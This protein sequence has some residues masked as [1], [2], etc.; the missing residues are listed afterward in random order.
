MS[1]LSRVFKN[2]LMLAAVAILMRT[3]GVGFNAYLKD[4][5]GE[6]GMGLVSLTLSVYGFAVTF[7]TSGL[8]LS[9]TRLVAEA[10]GLGRGRSIS[11]TLKA[12]LGYALFFGLLAGG[13]LFFASDG[14]ARVLLGD[15]RTRA[16]LR[17]LAFSLPPI[18]LSGV[19]Q[20]YFVAVGREMPRRVETCSTLVYGE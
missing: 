15:V 4:A 16:S 10:L 12:A 6:G 19:F 17:L 7:A 9:V 5:L 18:A 8:S 14:I 1:N 20:G 2:G 3:G 13:V 11:A